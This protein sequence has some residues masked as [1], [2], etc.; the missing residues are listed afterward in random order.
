M[1]RL[2]QLIEDH[3]TSIRQLAK[4]AGVPERT[5]YRHVKGETTPNIHQAAAYARALKVELSELA[6]DAA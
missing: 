4:D 1:T 2:A 3:G 6:E 5:V